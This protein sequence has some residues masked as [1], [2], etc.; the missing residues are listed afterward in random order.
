MPAPAVDPSTTVSGHKIALAPLATVSYARLAAPEPDA[1]EVR[2]LVTAA[3]SPGF[4]YLDLREAPDAGRY[5][6]QVQ[7]LY[8]LGGRFFREPE[9]AKMRNFV[10]GEEKGY[11]RTP[12]PFSFGPIMA[13]A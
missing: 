9:D 12:F 1:A 6:E 8:G 3:Q 4:F 11:E 10:E 13:G 5:I 2:K 7:A